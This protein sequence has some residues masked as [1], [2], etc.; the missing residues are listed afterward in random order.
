VVD[1]SG[2]AAP[3]LIVNQADSEIS[4][5]PGLDS[6]IYTWSLDDGPR[7]GLWVAPVP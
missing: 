3:V 2:G 1:L 5:S 4:M 6:V 7:A